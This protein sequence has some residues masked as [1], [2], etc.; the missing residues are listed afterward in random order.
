MAD[1]A[2][3]AVYSP[4]QK[5]IFAVFLPDLH[6]DPAHEISPGPFGRIGV[7]GRLSIQPDAPDL[8]GRTGFRQEGVSGAQQKGP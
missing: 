3:P 5:N 6:Q 8:V 4:V 2:D 1:G 7:S